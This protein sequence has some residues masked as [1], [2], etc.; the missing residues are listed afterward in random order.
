M[1]P[2]WLL[3]IVPF[4]VAFGFFGAFCLVAVAGMEVDDG[5]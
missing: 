4:C 2:W 1:N 3:L 5:C